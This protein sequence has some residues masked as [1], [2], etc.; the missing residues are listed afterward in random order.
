MGVKNDPIRW[1]GVMCGFFSGIT[2]LLIKWHLRVALVFILKELPINVDIEAL[3][4]SLLGSMR[5]V[6]VYWDHE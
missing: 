6:R 3:S 5:I 4:L 2:H 1:D